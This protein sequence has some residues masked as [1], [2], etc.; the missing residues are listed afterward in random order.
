MHV[1]VQFAANKELSPF[2]LSLA[3]CLRSVHLPE[4]L[5]CFLKTIELEEADIVHKKHP[6]RT[7]SNKSKNLDASRKGNAQMHMVIWQVIQISTELTC[8]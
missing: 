2:L 8:H 5:I 4:C 3:L 7:K 6:V 1:N